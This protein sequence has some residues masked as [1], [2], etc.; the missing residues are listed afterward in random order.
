MFFKHFGD[1]LF[2]ITTGC[3]NFESSAASKNEAI[4]HLD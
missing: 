4:R 3:E 1:L 2:Q